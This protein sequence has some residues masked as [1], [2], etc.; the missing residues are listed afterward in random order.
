MFNLIQKTMR[1]LITAALVSVMFLTTASA[2]NRQDAQQK[3]QP[4]VE[5][6][7]E[8]RTE[9]MVKMLSLDDKQKEQLYKL[10]LK[11][12]KKQRAAETKMAKLMK[13]AKKEAAQVRSEFE[14]SLKGILSAEQLQKYNEKKVKPHNPREGMSRKSMPENPAADCSAQENCCPK[15]CPCTAPAHNAGPQKGDGMHGG[16][17]KKDTARKPEIK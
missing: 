16:P 7:A 15:E 17:H 1:K 13:Q 8:Q 9:R 5:Q 2:Q 6:I 4:S 11:T 12:V 10:N 14:T 3:Q